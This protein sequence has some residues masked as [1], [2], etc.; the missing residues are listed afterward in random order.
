MNSETKSI[1]LDGQAKK[2]E[3]IWKRNLNKVEEPG[4]GIS[5]SSAFWMKGKTRNIEGTAGRP[6]LLQRSEQGKEGGEHL[7]EM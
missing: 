5:E 2:A 3:M 1:F 7:S 6:V 4:I